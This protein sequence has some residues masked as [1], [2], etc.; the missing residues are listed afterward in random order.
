MAIS[1]IVKVLYAPHKAFKDL[2]QG[3]ILSRIKE[4][5]RIMEISG[6]DYRDNL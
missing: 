4:M 2:S 5:C 1:D 6:D 3:R